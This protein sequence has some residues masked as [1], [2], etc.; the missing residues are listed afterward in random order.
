MTIAY[1]NNESAYLVGQQNAYAA[2]PSYYTASDPT[3][4]QCGAIRNDRS[5]RFCSSCGQAFKY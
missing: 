3:C 5:A 4:T 2:P 1:N